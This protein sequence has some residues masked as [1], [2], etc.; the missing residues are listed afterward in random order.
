MSEPR[1]N[2][3]NRRE[4][5]RLLGASGAGLAIGAGGST[6]FVKDRTKLDNPNRSVQFYGEHQAGISTTPQQFLHFAAFDFQTDQRDEI[7]RLLRNWSRAAEQMCTGHPLPAGNSYVG[8]PS[9]SGE[10]LDLGLQRLTLTFGFGPSFFARPAIDRFGIANLQPSILRDLPPF[11]NDALEAAMSGGDVCIQA[12]ADD[13]QIAFHAVRSLG[14]IAGDMA[15]RR[16]TQ[17]GFAPTTAVNKHVT[18]PRNLFGQ[19]DGTNNLKVEDQSFSDHVWVGSTDAPTWMSGGTY[20][21]ARRIRM[22]FD[23]WDRTPLEI[24]EQVLG[25]SKGTGAPLGK[26]S[27]F[28]A[29]DLNAKKSDGQNTVPLDAH[30]RLASPELNNDVRILRR[31]YSFDDGSDELHQINAGLFFISFQ[32]DI[33]AFSAIQHRLSEG[34]AMHRFLRHTASSVFACPPG[35]RPG[36]WIGETLFG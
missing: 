12:C 14:H 36:G 35:I 5:L 2:D 29:V 26:R 10:G 28:D 32:R 18:T 9:D 30:I 6:P 27:E 16:W 15:V 31:G 7:V 17:N 34:D 21:V 19:K 20:L 3:L 1:P 11:A 33:A 24:Q 8:G 13:P 22:A 4:F 25:R 23:I